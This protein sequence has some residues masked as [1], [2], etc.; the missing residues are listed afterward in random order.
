MDDH[1]HHSIIPSEMGPNVKHDSMSG[2]FHKELIF[3][4]LAINQTADGPLW[5]NAEFM[6]NAISHRTFKDKASWQDDAKFMAKT[7]SHRTFNDKASWKE[8]L[9]VPIEVHAAKE[10]QHEP[11]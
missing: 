11:P 5:A 3:L 1:H 9:T 8:R 4:Q 7:T 6:A 10:Q 2:K